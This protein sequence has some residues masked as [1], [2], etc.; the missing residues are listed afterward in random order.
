VKKSNPRMGLMA[1]LR[2]LIYQELSL[3]FSK[4]GGIALF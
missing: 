2:R 4:S 1:M 3:T